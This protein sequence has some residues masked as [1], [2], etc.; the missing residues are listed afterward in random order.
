MASTRSRGEYVTVMTYSAVRP[1]RGQNAVWKSE[2]WSTP[3]IARG[4]SACTNS[5]AR[6]PAPA[7]GSPI[8]RH[9][10]LPGPK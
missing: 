5:A 4:C 1:S 10:T 7:A 8:T 6:P 9:V 2:C 3:A